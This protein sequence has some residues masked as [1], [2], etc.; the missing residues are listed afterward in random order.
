MPDVCF[1]HNRGYVGYSER[2][3]IP[4]NKQEL[5]L[6]STINLFPI[7]AFNRTENKINTFKFSKY[8]INKNLIDTADY[9]QN[10]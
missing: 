1:L 6:I 3:S 2:I 8:H 7:Y 10:V 5:Y 9:K 4:Y